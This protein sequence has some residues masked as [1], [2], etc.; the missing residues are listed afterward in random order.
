LQKQKRKSPSTTTMTTFPLTIAL[1]LT[2][3]F[4][5]SSGAFFPVQVRTSPAHR[6][7]S[8]G[9]LYDPRSVDDEF[10]DF[11]TPSQRTFLKNEAAR[12]QARKEL[13][14]FCLP[15]NEMDGP[16]SLAT[17]NELWNDLSKNE[18]VL[19]R[20]ISKGD[21]KYVYGTAERICAELQTLQ[22]ELPITLLA[23]KGHTA[24]IFCPSL[25]LD[26]PLHVPL[27]TSVGQKNRWLARVKPPRDNRG[28]IIKE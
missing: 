26:N 3:T 19:V 5:Q 28:Q 23:T 10:V 18:L 12:R 24:T 20:G 13:V 27:R 9:V 21:K 15:P 6:T 7:D 25:P 1:A 4:I 17:L 8:L 22:S 16:F 11:P 2:L 14:T